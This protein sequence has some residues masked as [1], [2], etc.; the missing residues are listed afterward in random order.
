MDLPIA[1]RTISPAMTARVQFVN[2]LVLGWSAGEQVC[3][4]KQ[5]LALAQ[6]VMG[7]ITRYIAKCGQEFWLAEVQETNKALTRTQPPSS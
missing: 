6:P 4:T 1:G 7:Y 2:G 5:G 3:R